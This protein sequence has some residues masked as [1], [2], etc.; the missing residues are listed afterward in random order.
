MSV[1]YRALALADLENIAGYLGP[2]SPTGARNVL[3]ALHEAIAQ[4]ERYPQSAIE[5]SFPGIRVRIIG[6]YRY[7]I[8]YF[9]AGDGAIEI[10]HI[11]HAARRP[12]AGADG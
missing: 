4:I 3:R 11:R 2:R 8:F 10:I 6:R 12:W 7:K 1:R 5:T 9:V